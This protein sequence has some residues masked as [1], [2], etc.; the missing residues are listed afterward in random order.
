MELTTFE[1]QV[2]STKIRYVH[3]LGTNSCKKMNVATLN[4]VH[5]AKKLANVNLRDLLKSLTG[6][7]KHSIL[8]VR[9][10]LNTPLLKNKALFRCAKRTLD[11]ATSNE[12][13]RDMRFET[14]Q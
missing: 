9:G 14:F 5:Q 4:S 1:R 12:N 7:A 11:T 8:D 13:L 2:C 10:V 6:Y 3:A